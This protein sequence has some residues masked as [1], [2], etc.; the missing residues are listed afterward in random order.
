MEHEWRDRDGDSFGVDE[1]G[2]YRLAQDCEGFRWREYLEDP[3]S[4]IAVETIAP[5]AATEILR[6]TEER[7]ALLQAKAPEL[8]RAR[9]A[10]I[11]RELLAAKVFILDCPGEGLVSVPGEEQ[12]GEWAIPIAALDRIWPAQETLHE[13]APSEEKPDSEA[14]ADSCERKEGSESPDTSG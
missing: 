6:L 5:A 4:G 13:E 12:T 11:R 7:E 9:I 14:S 2:I 3:S 10:R 8:E 1:R